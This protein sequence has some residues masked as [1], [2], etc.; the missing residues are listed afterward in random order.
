MK[1]FWLKLEFILETTIFLELKGCNLSKNEMIQSKHLSP[2]L[3][4][5]AQ[6]FSLSFAMTSFHQSNISIPSI[7][8]QKVSF[9]FKTV[10]N[11]R[12]QQETPRKTSENYPKQKSWKTKLM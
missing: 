2:S 7:S 6:L 10:K 1:S 8:I 11:R 4:V 3:Q 9:Y 5:L 12:I